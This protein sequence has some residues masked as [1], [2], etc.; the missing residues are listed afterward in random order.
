MR[1]ITND[2]RF[3]ARQVRRNPGVAVIAV[4][5][6]TL[7]IGLTTT[8]FSFVYGVLLR[9]LPYEDSDRIVHVDRTHLARGVTQMDVTI[10]DFEDWRARQRSFEQLGAFYYGTVNISGSDKPERY[11]GAFV[12]ANTFDLLRVKPLLG[13]VLT[14]ADERKGAE[15]VIVLGYNVWRDRFG[16]DPDVVGTYVRA[17]GE[18]ARII[19]VMP[20]KFAFPY[21]QQMWLPLR[22]DAAALPRGEGQLVEVFGRLLPGV[23]EERA[24]VEI[25]QIAQQLAAEHPVTNEGVGVLVQSF[26]D[27]LAGEGAAMLYT[28]LGAVMLVLL[29]ACA[30][31]ANLLLG[32]AAGRSQEVAVRTALGAT[33]GRVVT[34]FLTETLVLASVGAVLGTGLAVFGTR[35][36]NSGLQNF[37][38]LPAFIEVRMDGMSLLFVLVTTLVATLAA[39]VLPALQ[40]ARAEAGAIL[41][42]SARGSSS[43]RIGRMSRAIVVA[44]IALSCGLLVTSGLM[45][46]SIVNLSNADYGFRTSNVFTARLGLPEGRYANGENRRFFEELQSRLAALPGVET[47]SLGSNIPVASTITSVRRQPFAVEG[48]AYARESDY[49]MTG[50]LI[51][52]PGYFA[53][54]GVAPRQGREFTAAD[55]AETQ[56]VAIVNE[57]FVRTHLNGEDA[58]GRRIRFGGSDSKEPWRTIVAV[59]PDLRI[60]G[61]DDDEPDGVYVPFGQSPQRFASIILHTSVEPLSLTGSVRDVVASLDADLP[62]FRVTTLEGAI[63]HETWFYRL[64]GGIFTTFGAVALFLAAVGL[65]GV[66]ALSVKRRTREVGVRMALGAQVH[67]VLRLV[68]GQGLRQITIG[69]VFGLGLAFL[70]SKFLVLMLFEVNPRDP[71]IFGGVMATLVLTGSVACLVPAL[72]ATR[73][74]PVIAIR[75][76]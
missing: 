45:I 52:A 50:A 7:G 37:E 13:R 67:N 25:N 76:E 60:S 14:A 71:L 41:K 16:R 12:T 42:D 61:P 43:F 10:H 70:V 5:A 55:R 57:S 68:L 62:I 27:S 75:T 59:V 21:V 32:R 31:V 4:L 72:R 20:E 73:V 65:Y 58:I 54:L 6:L 53:A 47:A 64:F 36:L 66:M 51:A 40:A 74:D 34:Q 9:G 17:N 48:R 30:N 29:V 1:N 26:I 49:R 35:I 56:Q 15:L 69:L 63:D 28:M 39:G 19:G 2:L 23:S 33:R 24:N 18:P 3:G 11:S 46:R 38:G 44:E 8:V 22:L